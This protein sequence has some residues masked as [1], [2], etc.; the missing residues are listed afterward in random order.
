MTYNRFLIVG[1]ILSF[2]AAVLHLACIIGGPDWYMALGAGEQMA[3]MAAN[4]ELYPTLVTIGIASILLCWGLYALSATGA[5]LRLPFI[6]L[7]LVAIS[8]VYTLRGLAGLVLAFFP[9]TQT[10]YPSFS[11][12][13]WSSLICLG[14]GLVHIIGLYQHWPFMGGPAMTKQ[15]G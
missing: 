1:A 4:G 10:D 2:A 6:K 8:F 3:Q 11:F 5:F 7:A 9:I 15:S 14:Y 12:M 13:I